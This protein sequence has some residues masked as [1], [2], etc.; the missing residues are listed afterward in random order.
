MAEAGR[1][2]RR[3]RLGRMLSFYHRKTAAQGPIE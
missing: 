1:I 2:V 3:K